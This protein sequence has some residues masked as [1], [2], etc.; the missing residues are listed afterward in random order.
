MITLESSF[1]STCKKF[2]LAQSEIEEVYEFV[3]HQ[4]M[5]DAYMLQPNFEVSIQRQELIFS[6]CRLAQEGPPLAY[7]IGKKNFYGYDF[8]CCP[9][10]LIPRFDTE[11]LVERAIKEIKNHNFKTIIDLGCGSGCVGLT[12][13]LESKAS[14]V[15]GVDISS[16]AIALTN[17]NKMSLNVG[18]YQTLVADM[19][20]MPELTGSF[21]L[22]VSNP[23]YIAK[24]DDR[25]DLSV[26]LYEPHLALYGEQEGLEFYQTIA[27]YGLRA[28]T[29]AGSILVEFSPFISQQ[30]V[31][32][33]QKLGYHCVEVIKDL[34]QHERV[35]HFR[36]K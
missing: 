2:K 22:I 33:F 9:G 31:S 14:T 21:D 3:L 28:L 30:V 19:R 8:H 16:Q 36:L 23:P 1:L 6:L 26:S 4:K 25:V 7:V 32:T 10:V 12:I 5:P 35:G 13:A 20:D 15:L 11:V 34:Q 17:K 27:Q 29:K 18:H 24:S